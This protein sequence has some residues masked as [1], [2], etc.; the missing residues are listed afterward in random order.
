M[1]HFSH[2]N[3]EGIVDQ[4]IVIDE[5]T[6]ATGHWGDP[7]E[8]V[9]TS[10]N[11]SSGDYKRGNTEQEKLTL[12]VSGT[13]KDIQARNRKNFAGVGFTYNSVL[14]AFIPPTPFSGWVLNEDTCQWE[15]PVPYPQDGQT[16]IWDN[17]LLDWVTW[18]P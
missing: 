12:K 10:Y 17:D 9:Q 15:S 11:T 7:S 16:Y 18:E 2:I 6:L 13:T 4:V 8:W 14:D 5:A 3:N 1:A